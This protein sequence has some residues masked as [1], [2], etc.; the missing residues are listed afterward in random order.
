MGDRLDLQ[1]LLESVLGGDSVY[2]QPPPTINMSY[3][4]IVYARSDI[5]T[6]FADNNPYSRDKA[7]T[8]TVIDSN[9]DSLIPDKLAALPKCAF[10]RHYAVDNLNHDVFTLYF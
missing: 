1:T 8:V 10:D 9:P 5:R 4:C 6:T 7:Y 2:F 3:P